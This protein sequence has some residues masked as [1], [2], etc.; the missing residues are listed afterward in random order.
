MRQKSICLYGLW[1]FHGIFKKLINVI[2]I[3]QLPI[4]FRTPEK[5][6][7]ELFGDLSQTRQSVIGQYVDN[8]LM[9]LFDQKQGPDIK[10]R[11]RL[12]RRKKSL[13]RA[14]YQDQFDQ[15]C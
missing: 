11:H 9:D 12:R 3:R 4:I 6:I 10:K 8:M 7:F 15:A 5:K 14:A 1:F 2:L 13:I